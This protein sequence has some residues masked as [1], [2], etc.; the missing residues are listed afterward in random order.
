MMGGLLSV[1]MTWKV[2]PDPY[3]L[4]SINKPLKFLQL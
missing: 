2:P 1:T 3:S 4:W